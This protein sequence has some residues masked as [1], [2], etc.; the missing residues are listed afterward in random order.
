MLAMLNNSIGV[1][2]DV[3]AVNIDGEGVL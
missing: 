3:H 2:A 1:T